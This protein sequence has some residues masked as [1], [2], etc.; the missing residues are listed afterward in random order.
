[1]WLQQNCVTEAKWCDCSMVQYLWLHCVTAENWCYCSIWL[2]CVTAENWCDCRKIMWLHFDN[3]TNVE[4]VAPVCDCSKIVWL[5][6]SGVT[7][8]WCSICDCTV[9]LQKIDV[10]AVYDC[11]VW[12]QKKCVT[13]RDVWYVLQ[14]CKLIF[15]N[16]YYTYTHIN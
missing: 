1:M 7:V 13:R 16:M 3:C 15:S 8:V 5:R 2:Q 10:T 12:P 6:Q 4:Y 14:L 9:W 11:N